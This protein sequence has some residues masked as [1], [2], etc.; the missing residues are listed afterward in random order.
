MQII[1]IKENLKDFNPGMPI[2]DLFRI[3]KLRFLIKQTSNE[4]LVFVAR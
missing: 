1:F 4:I 2:L 3:E